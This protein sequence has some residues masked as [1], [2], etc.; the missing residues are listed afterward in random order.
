[1]SDFFGY[2]CKHF[3]RH[4]TLTC[5]KLHREWLKTL[6]ILVHVVDMLCDEVCLR[7]AVIEHVTAERAK[8]DEIG[9]RLRPEVNVGTRRHLMLARVGYD[10]RLA[11]E[12][13]RPL[14]SCR[15]HRVTLR[16]IAADDQHQLGHPNI[17]DRTGVAAI[18]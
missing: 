15:K 2:F 11:K 3:D 8:P 5:S 18:T 7:I 12:L 9:T 17:F 14:C 1:M 6:A 10:Q 16:R 4:V 13:V